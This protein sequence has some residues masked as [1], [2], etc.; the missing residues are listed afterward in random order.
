M[1]FKMIESNI[2]VNSFNFGCWDVQRLFYAWNRNRSKER[3]LGEFLLLSNSFEGYWNE[4]IRVRARNQYHKDLGTINSLFRKIYCTSDVKDER[5]RQISIT[6]FYFNRKRTKWSY[7]S[8]TP[9]R[10][11]PRILTVQAEQ[12]RIG[13]MSD[14]I[15]F[16]LSQRKKRVSHETYRAVGDI[17]S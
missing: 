7:F 14:K 17:T 8:T 4:T 5:L 13:L 15:H 1:K 11:L 12:V 10:I 6:N 16:L 2:I 3:Q 9:S